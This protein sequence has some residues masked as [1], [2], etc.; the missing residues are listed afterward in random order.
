M[1]IPGYNYIG[2]AGDTI[3]LLADSEGCHES[4]IPEIMADVAYQA[5]SVN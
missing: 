2:V 3:G 5:S 4:C 1:V